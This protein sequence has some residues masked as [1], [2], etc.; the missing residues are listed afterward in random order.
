MK[1]ATKLVETPMAVAILSTLR[2]DLNHAADGH[3][4]NVVGVGGLVAL[5]GS[6]VHE[7]FGGDPYGVVNLRLTRPA[8][9]L[10]KGKITFIFE[11]SVAPMAISR[12]GN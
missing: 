11:L 10:S 6:D 5:G 8:P 7:E 9:K 12:K 3:E 2:D 1:A 4:F